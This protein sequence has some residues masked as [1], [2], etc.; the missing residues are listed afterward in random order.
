MC[1]AMITDLSGVCLCV[2]VADCSPIILLDEIGGAIGVAHAGR[3][4]VCQKILTKTAI[5]MSEC[6]GTKISDLAVFV[7]ANI[8]GSCYEVGDLDL[9]EFERFKNENKFDMNLALKAEFDELGIKNYKF[10][11]IC[12]HCENSLYSYRRDHQTGRFCGFAMIKEKNV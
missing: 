10:S 4:G 12:T 7:G 9:G 1:D 5:K 2:M 3:N 11:Q 6:Y 8:K